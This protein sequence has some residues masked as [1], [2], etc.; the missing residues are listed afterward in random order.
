M[1]EIRKPEER[2][3]RIMFRMMKLRLGEMP[4]LDYE[5]SFPQMELIGF[6]KRFP[7]CRVQDI[8]DGLGITPP[9]VSVGLKRLEKAGWLERHP[10]PQDRRATCISLTHKSNEMLQRVKSAQSKG[11]QQFLIGLSPD[12][13]DQLIELLEKAI[14]AAEARMEAQNS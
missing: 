6:V 4:R 11:I 14:T 2:L 8:A 3:A 10:D 7:N 1:T 5:I 9:S 13:K 12:E